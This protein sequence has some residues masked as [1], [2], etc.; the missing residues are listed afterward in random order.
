[1]QAKAVKKDSIEYR[2]QK[3]S[4]K[5]ISAYMT[6]D[7]D[8]FTKYSAKLHKLRLSTDFEK[9]DTNRQFATQNAMANPQTIL[10]SKN[11]NL[12]LVHCETCRF[13]DSKRLLLQ[14]DNLYVTQPSQCKSVGRHF[15]IFPKRHVMSICQLEKKEY[16]E[17]LDLKS[18]IVSKFTDKKVRPLFIEISLNFDK[19]RHAFCDVYLIDWTHDADLV[20]NITSFLNQL[21]SET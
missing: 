9:G 6:H 7:E 11:S 18:A 13:S 1:M 4:S 8:K 20:F 3:Y 14:T 12:S 5:L 17:L 15:T 2:N 19:F 16:D 10:T 21:T